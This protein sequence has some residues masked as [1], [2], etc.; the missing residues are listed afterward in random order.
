MSGCS[1]GPLR[2]SPA[3]CTLQRTP[4]NHRPSCCTRGGKSVERL[5]PIFLLQLLI[6]GD[7]LGGGGFLSGA[8]SSEWVQ[9]ED[10]ASISRFH[11]S[12]IPRWYKVAHSNSFPFPFLHGPSQYNSQVFSGMTKSAIIR[13][14][15]NFYENDKNIKPQ[16]LP[17]HPPLYTAGGFSGQQFAR[18]LSIGPAFVVWF[19]RGASPLGSFGGTAAA[20]FTTWAV[21]NSMLHGRAGIVQRLEVSHKNIIYCDLYNF[22]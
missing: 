5:C 18:P 16:N 2:N 17:N 3:S 20:G 22:R 14:A 12:T 7:R 11:T 15:I 8:T 1:H 4:G 10:C 21:I 19:P 6:D 13:V 9:G